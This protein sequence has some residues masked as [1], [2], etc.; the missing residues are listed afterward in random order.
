[1]PAHDSPAAGWLLPVVDRITS[2]RNKVVYRGMVYTASDFRIEPGTKLNIRAFPY[3]YER[4]P[5]H[6]FVEMENGYLYY[7]TAHS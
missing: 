7:L 1:M 6:I 3:L 2:G 4:M 5:L